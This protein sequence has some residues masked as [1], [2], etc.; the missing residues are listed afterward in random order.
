M[1]DEPIYDQSFTKC[2]SKIHVWRDKHIIWIEGRIVE[3]RLHKHHAFQVSW[4]TPGTTINLK[5]DAQVIQGRAVAVDG[6]VMHSLSME[7]GVIALVDSASITATWLRERLLHKK[8]AAS[9][10]ESGDETSVMDVLRSPILGG[11]GQT[12]WVEARDE[13]IDRVLDWLDELEDTRQWD[14]VSLESAL[15]LVHLSRSRFLHLFSARVGSPWRTYLVWRRA[16]IAITL[17]ND[18]FDLQRNSF[19]WV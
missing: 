1:S 14:S 5:T 2:D 12:T 13:R 6:R 19:E 18:G 10:E 11:E 16:L 3:N 9:F 17:A 4:A 7:S 8:T 15:K